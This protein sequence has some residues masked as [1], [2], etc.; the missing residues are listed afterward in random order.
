MEAV[1]ETTKWDVPT[2]AHVYLLDGDRAVAYQ[3]AIDGSIKYFKKPIQI[4]KRGRTFVKVKVS[5]FKLKSTDEL[6]TVASS[7]GAT[8]TVNLTKKT[9]NCPGFSFRGKCKHITE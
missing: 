3:N 5:P 2:P 7:K 6:V 8:Y 1:I 4:S 9:C